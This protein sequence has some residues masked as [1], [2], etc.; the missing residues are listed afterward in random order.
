VRGEVNQDGRTDVSDPVAV[1]RF[2]FG[3]GQI[4]CEKAADFDDSGVIDV[5]DVIAGLGTLFQGAA[6][7]VAP[8]PLCGTDPTSDT[9]SCLEPVCHE[10]EGSIRI[11]EILASNSEGL[12]DE[13]DNSSDWIEIHMPH[14]G[15]APSI[16]LEGWALSNNPNRP[17]W[18]FPAGVVLRKGEFLVVFASGEDRR[19]AGSELHTDFRLDSDGEFVALIAPDE[20]VVD[21]FDPTYPE[22]RLDIS[23]GP[24]NPRTL[25]VG[26]DDAVDYLV[27]TILN[28]ATG[29]GWTVPDF[30][31]FGWQ[32][33]RNGLGFTSSSGEGFE[34]TLIKANVSV[35]DLSVA[36]EVVRNP[37]LQDSVTT[38]SA[39]E[40]NY[41][42]TGPA[43]NFRLDD[44]FPSLAF[45]DVEDFVVLVTGTITVPEAGLWT[46]GVSNDDGFR[47]EISDGAHTYTMSHSTPRA[48]TNTIEVFDIEQAGPHSVSLLYFQRDGGASLELFAAEGAFPIYNFFATRRSAWTSCLTPSSSSTPTATFRMR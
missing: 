20:T 44:M 27:P 33:G 48:V 21:S 7:P 43:G 16:N 15:A 41:L 8:F 3:P 45:E 29:T 28:A 47:L 5:T 46:L 24:V 13:D 25:F 10:F 19:E 37:A 30:A 36:E 40:I 6:Q 31:P 32:E 42:T 4:P 1:L 11:N 18:L 23:Y 39:T 35:D 2:L 22:Q 12:R 34:I 17:G 38:E 26:P 14:N 9:L